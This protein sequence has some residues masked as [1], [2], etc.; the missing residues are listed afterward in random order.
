MTHPPRSRPRTVLYIA[1]AAAAA[2]DGAAALEA[3]DSGPDRTVQPLSTSAI[4]QLRSW[5]PEADCV[6]FAETPTTAAGAGLLEIVD[7]CGRTPL[8]LFC[9]RSYAPTAARSTDGIAGYV[10]RG[11][12]DAMAHLA[13]EIE[14]VCRGAAVD[15]DETSRGEVTAETDRKTDVQPNG[16][17]ETTADETVETN[18]DETADARPAEEPLA[19]EPVRPGDVLGSADIAETDARAAVVSSLE[20]AT[21]LAAWRDHESGRDRCYELLVEFAADACGTDYCWLSTDHLG[22]FTTRAATDAVPDDALESM[23]LEGPVGDAFRRGEPFRID[24]VE[25]AA[26]EPPFEEAGSLYVAPVGDVGVVQIADTEPDAFDETTGE[27]LETC[28]RYASAILERAETRTRLRAERDRLRLERTQLEDERDRFADERDRIGDER[29][30]LA[31]D[32]DRLD[33]AF[34]SLPVPA[35]R[36]ELVDDRAV[37]RAVTD[38]F[39]DTFDIDR[40]AVVDSAI[41]AADDGSSGNSSTDIADGDNRIDAD[42]DNKLNDNGDDGIGDTDC[43][44]TMPPGL[45]DRALTLADAVRSTEQRQFVSRRETADGIRTFRLTVAPCSTAADRESTDDTVA[46]DDSTEAVVVYTDVTDANRM[47]RELAAV[48]HRLETIAQLVDEDV[49]T[50]LNVARGYLELAAE[51]G[52]REHFDEI[53]DAQDQLLALVEQL[54]TIARRDDVLVDTEPVALH[55]VARRA[56]VVVETG[57]ARLVTEE[58]LVLE[59]DKSRVQELF[60]HLFQAIVHGEETAEHDGSGPEWRADEGT[61]DDEAVTR[62]TDEQTVVSVG[63]ADDGFYVTGRWDGANRTVAGVKSG[64]DLGRLAT[65]DGAGFGLDPIERIAGAHGWDIGIAEDDD[66]IAFAFR[67]VECDTDGS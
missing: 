17:V 29:D 43:E 12:D 11:T 1:E 44:T 34:A 30:R 15:G 49:R 32:R 47:E 50:P 16:P 65:C 40:T 39:T 23:P 27:I 36:Y 13:D 35:L 64:A 60:E 61:I 33:A 53:D 42:G 37:V 21:E 55:D 7:A 5:A 2:R 8:V 22:E 66:R 57:N 4:D 18:T 52:D 45:E 3:V 48:E 24:D 19:V 14:W 9:E 63:T 28:C 31:V 67:G 46:G 54:L 51:T 26:L 10:R 62:I 20:S 41:G 58:N 59:A 25:D 6:V 56:W 38:R